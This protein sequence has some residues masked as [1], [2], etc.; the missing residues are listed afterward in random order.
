MAE[1]DWAAELKAYLTQVAS[2]FW[3]PNDADL[4]AALEAG[5]DTLKAFGETGDKDSKVLA[6]RWTTHLPAEAAAAE[7]GDEPAADAP[8]DEYSV[9]AEVGFAPNSSYLVLVKS[10]P[11]S[12]LDAALPITAQ[13]RFTTVDGQVTSGEEGH[14][15]KAATPYD[16]FFGLL[17]TVYAPLV[18]TYIVD[19]V[20]DGQVTSAQASVKESMKR[21]EQSLALARGAYTF[22]AVK[23]DI[24]PE[25]AATFEEKGAAFTV[26]DLASY[27]DEAKKKNFLAALE[28]NVNEWVNEIKRV[29][30]EDRVD[31]LTQESIMR[32][33]EFFKGIGPQSL[34]HRHVDPPPNPPPCL[35][36]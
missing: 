33:V 17:Q 29:T 25:I 14:A 32:D 8:K 16:N 7:G 4:A 34:K 28:T 23:L 21:M 22:Q 35:L 13:T 10:K 27:K 24:H 1:K 12:A 18:N 31:S 36:Y 6:L 5:A 9:S 2:V 3:N 19:A 15:T 26:D 11:L 20:G 30:G